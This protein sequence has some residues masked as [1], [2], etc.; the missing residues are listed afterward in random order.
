MVCA[1]STQESDFL[2]IIFCCVQRHSYNLSLHNIFLP[3]FPVIHRTSNR[4]KT[5]NFLW[6]SYIFILPL[7]PFSKWKLIILKMAL[8]HFVFL[9]GKCCI[10]YFEWNLCANSFS[11]EADK[12]VENKSRVNWW[13]LSSQVYLISFSW[14]LKVAS[15]ELSYSLR[16]NI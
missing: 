12:S 16:K 15:G 5:Q 3:F 1:L 4:K 7:I 14:T 11:S 2:F 6:T 10:L 13:R 9:G 8:L